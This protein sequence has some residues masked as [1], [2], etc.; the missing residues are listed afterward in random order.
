MHSNITLSFNFG[1]EHFWILTEACHRALS[2]ILGFM[3]LFSLYHTKIR[4]DLWG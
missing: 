2:Y 1:V 3:V 4:L